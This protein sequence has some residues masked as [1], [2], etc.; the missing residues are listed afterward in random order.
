M[1][2]PGNCQSSGSDREPEPSLSRVNT[3]KSSSQMGSDSTSHAWQAAHI[4]NG[5]GN[6][7]WYLAGFWRCPVELGTQPEVPTK[8]PMICLPK[9]NS[10]GVT[11][12]LASLLPPLWVP[13]A[14]PGGCAGTAGAGGRA[15]HRNSVPA[16]VLIH[17][18]S[19]LAVHFIN[20]QL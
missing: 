15:W 5:I 17:Q 11:W 1:T 16:P 10:S 13:R 19:T 14:C 6:P 7:L 4:S 3:P 18:N 9:E 12:A 20:T 8:S 2:S